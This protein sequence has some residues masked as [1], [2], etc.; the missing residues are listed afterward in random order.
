MQLTA[1]YDTRLTFVAADPDPI[2]GSDNAWSLPLFP[3][4]G[5]MGMVVV[6]LTTASLAPDAVLHSTLRL[7]SA[8]TG[9]V[10]HEE[11]TEAEAVDLCLSVSYD[12]NTPYPGKWIT[13]TLHYTNDGDIP[14]EGVVLTATLPAG[15]R[16]IDAGQ[17]WNDAGDGYY[18]HT[19]D[20]VGSG[21]GG[22]VQF[23][24]MVDSG[25]S[26]SIQFVLQVLTTA[27][28]RLPSELT[29][30]PTFVV[31][32][33]GQNGPELDTSNNQAVGSVG[34]PD[35]VIDEMWVMLVFPTPGRPV[36]FTVVL[37]NQGTGLA[38]NPNVPGGGG[39]WVD[40]FIDPASAPQSY[41]WNGD[42]DFLAFTVA[43]APGET[44]EIVF[45]LPDGLKDQ[46]HQV[47]AKVDNF[48]DPEL[49]PWQQNSLVP[50]SDEENNVALISVAMV[51][52]PE[53]H[54][55]LPVVLNN[56]LAMGEPLEYHVFL[57]VV[58]NNH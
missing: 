22:S 26:G 40:L 30:E 16:H 2:G 44:R 24:S 42:G 29:L 31:A 7:R 18:T 56:H 21:A 28:G 6:T 50:E 43:L 39:F 54:V 55:F 11:T 36:T 45:E 46:D 47:Y 49:E 20:M 58:L 5:G 53:Y 27:D 41:P 14:A 34:L 35:L 57:P 37:H 1:D 9:W 17:G 51:E 8:E 52:P 48:R 15:T 10:S 25:A 19:L 4:E 38:G 23:L 33:N 12:D 13:Y 32:D 3:G